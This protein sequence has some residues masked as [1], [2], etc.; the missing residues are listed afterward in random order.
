[1]QKTCSKIV[2]GSLAIPRSLSTCET[3]KIHPLRKLESY[4]SF[5]WEC[6]LLKLV[7]YIISPML[8]VI[9]CKRPHSKIP[10]RFPTVIKCLSASHL[11]KTVKYEISGNF[12]MTWSLKIGWLF[13]FIW[14][15]DMQS[16]QNITW[17]TTELKKYPMIQY[18][19]LLTKRNASFKKNTKFALIAMGFELFCHEPKMTCTQTS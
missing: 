9:T 12:R 2:H 10:H 16:F 3:T 8:L 4:I 11:R 15:F 6:N 19:T 13:Q 14:Y 1:M 7:S 18:H 17:N 5:F